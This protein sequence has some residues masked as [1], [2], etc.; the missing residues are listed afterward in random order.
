MK[1]DFAMAVENQKSDPLAGISSAP[2]AAR[3]LPSV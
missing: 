2:G 1:R 3:L